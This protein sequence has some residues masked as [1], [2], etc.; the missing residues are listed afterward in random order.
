[1]QEK[2]LVLLTTGGVREKYRF[3]KNLT[4]EPEICFVIPGS[5][6]SP[7]THDN[8]ILLPYRSGFIHSDLVN[9]ADAV[10]GKAGYSTI[11]EV[12]QAGVPFGY[13]PRSNFRET[14]KLVAFIEK[15]MKGICIGDEEFKAGNWLGKVTRLLNFSRTKRHNPNGSHQAAGMIRD[16]LK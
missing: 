2:K 13:V 15:E 8:L 3:L 12:Y 9:T 10:V 14:D 1:L 5:S 6:E 16:I 4:A 11:A 7:E